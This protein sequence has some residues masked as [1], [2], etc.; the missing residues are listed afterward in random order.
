MCPVAEIEPA[1]S[2]EA[3]CAL[4]DAQTTGSE[5]E[6]GIGRL[7]AFVETHCTEGATSHLYLHQRDVLSDT[8]D[9]LEAG[10]RRGY[11]RLPTGSGKTAEFATLAE[12][13][14]LK[15]LVLVPNIKLVDQ[16]VQA[17]A[18]FA[19]DLSVSTFY[20]GNKSLDG[21]CVVC[22]YQSLPRL[23]A[24]TGN[25]GADFGLIVC[26]EAHRALA[27]D[28]SRR[29]ETLL[30]GKAG[31]AYTATPRFSEAK[32]VSHL[33]PDLI[34]EMPLTEAIENGILSGARCIGVKTDI[35]LGSVKISQGDYDPAQLE[36]AVNVATR[37]LAAVQLLEHPLNRGKSA[38][39]FCT[40]VRHAQEVARL[41]SA[42]GIKAAAVDGSMPEEI[43]KEIYGQ[44]DR[45][46]IS[47]LCAA[48]LLNEGWDA[49][50]AEIGLMLAPTRSLVKAEQRGGRMLRLWG[51]EQGG[52]KRYAIFYEF[53]DN[54]DASRDV[55]PI[56]MV[57]VL[58]GAVV[59]PAGIQSI[60]DEREQSLAGE[61][62][63]FLSL[64]GFEVVLEAEKLLELT[65]KNR[66]AR[67]RIFN[68]P[69]DARAMLEE[70]GID[71]ESLARHTSK[72]PFLAMRISTSAFQ[73]SGRSFVR[74]YYEEVHGES[75]EYISAEKLKNFFSEVFGQEFDE[76][77]VAKALRHVK[78]DHLQRP[79]E[80]ILAL[81]ETEA[82]ETEFPI[83]IKN[84]T[85]TV[86]LEDYLRDAG[87]RD[88]EGRTLHLSSALT[89]G[90]LTIREAAQHH[91]RWQFED[92]LFDIALKTYGIEGADAY[93]RRWHEAGG[94][95]AHAEAGTLETLF[96]DACTNTP[97]I[98][99]ATFAGIEISDGRQRTFRGSA[100]LNYLDISDEQSFAEYLSEL[101][102][103]EALPAL[104]RTVPGADT[105]PI[106]QANVRS[107]LE[108]LIVTGP[109]RLDTMQ[110][111]A[112]PWRVPRTLQVREF[113][114][115]LG[116]R[117][118]VPELGLDHHSLRIMAAWSGMNPEAIDAMITKREDVLAVLECRRN[119]TL[120]GALCSVA[121]LPLPKAWNLLPDLKFRFG[122]RIVPGA[123]VCELF[124]IKDAASY[125]QF[126]AQVIGNEHFKAQWMALQN[127][128]AA[129]MSLRSEVSL[130]QFGSMTFDREGLRISGAHVMRRLGL[131]VTQGNFRR[132]MREIT[133]RDDVAQRFWP[134]YRPL[135]GKLFNDSVQTFKRNNPGAPLS[136][137]CIPLVWDGPPP[138]GCPATTVAE[139]M[140]C[141]YANRA[142]ADDADGFVE[143]PRRWPPTL[144]QEI[145]SQF[146]EWLRGN[147]G[148]A[149]AT[150]AA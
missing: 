85:R 27:P 100:I 102:K 128:I 66:Q 45:G 76:H 104:P 4:R 121:V 65:S 47:L 19:P 125:G 138:K 131:E 6:K 149:S 38:V 93:L 95:R 17:M 98:D 50:R 124:D 58:G 71:A 18:R 60:V 89:T 57:D 61:G 108:R 105:H 64:Q 9:W 46:E 119:G 79:L 74:R 116:T 43:R 13:M 2:P 42:H 118:G 88:E 70:S 84:H 129:R 122:E 145:R 62:T 110:T 90:T 123:V 8:L 77:A 12:A 35:D 115:E 30:E 82:S 127:S 26:D 92:I 3:P 31:I 68:S 114:T 39:A 48:E 81:T 54:D 150:N 37:N 16:T 11:V 143:V 132:L 55:A 32:Q 72:E 111:G 146:L 117:I 51:P 7:R 109:E 20:G 106:T 69:E 53:I 25:D 134:N 113:L 83:Y 36:K 34:H 136:P 96:L 126:I 40:S 94:I 41:A 67:P 28:R 99:M 80:A 91:S 14:R 10:G 24:A 137:S 112:G 135:I 63:P 144:T 23:L 21:Q 107:F 52:D 56:T 29:I 15:T 103:Q 1:T 133:G 141:W 78:K 147:D 75:L 130:H 87:Y 33:F 49:P 140:R 142:V 73:G 5:F 120:T 148:A 101:G 139:L 22:T 44:Y 59:L 97:E 86:R